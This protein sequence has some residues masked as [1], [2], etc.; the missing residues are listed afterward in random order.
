MREGKL[1]PDTFTMCKTDVPI[2]P[3]DKTSETQLAALSDEDKWLYGIAQKLSS[4]VEL[5]K[6]LGFGM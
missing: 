4:K 3:S 1:P 5:P 2:F 6:L